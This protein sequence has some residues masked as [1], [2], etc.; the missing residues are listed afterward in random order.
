VDRCSAGVVMF[1]SV[2]WAYR[3]ALALAFVVA[4]IVL[5]GVLFYGPDQGDRKELKGTDNAITGVAPGGK[6]P[7]IEH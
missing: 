4:L 2:V 3:R 7:S 5:A 6:V 1:W